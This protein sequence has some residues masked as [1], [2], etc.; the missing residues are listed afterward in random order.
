MI[1]YR[2]KDENPYQGIIMIDWGEKGIGTLFYKPGEQIDF[3]Q[4]VQAG[5]VR[6]EDEIRP[7]LRS[8][9]LADPVYITLAAR[10][11]SDF[12]FELEQGN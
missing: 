9:W 10:V 3:T 1:M 11:A 8:R 5:R 7:V 12:L 4:A 2:E 6:V